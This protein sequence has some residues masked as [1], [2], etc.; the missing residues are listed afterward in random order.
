MVFQ[1]VA[2]DGEWFVQ[3][4]EDESARW[5]SQAGGFADEAEAVQWW[6]RSDRA[7]PRMGYPLVWLTDGA[8]YCA[9]CAR[10]QWEAG[11]DSRAD[12]ETGRVVEFLYQDSTRDGM[13]CEC[14]EWIEEPGCMNCGRGSDAC[15]HQFRSTNGG[16]A[17][18]CRRCMAQAVIDA[19]D[20]RQTAFHA[21]KTGKRTYVLNE[22]FYDRTY[23]YQGFYAAD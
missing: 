4:R 22:R 13:S 8:V 6:F 11:G 23:R 20:D 9:A 5:Q 16:G 3:T 18:L 10:Q 14:G 1:I 15:E 17:F 12:I 2:I 7:A 21:H 19:I